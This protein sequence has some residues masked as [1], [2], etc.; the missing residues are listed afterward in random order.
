M[1]RP[2]L[3]DV[4][5]RILGVLIEKAF[6]TP[7]QYPLSINAIINGSN[8]KSN[9]DPV[10][11]FTE[12]EIVVGLQGLVPKHLA[13]RA[14][15][16]SSRVDKYQHSAAQALGLERRGLAILAELLMRGP[17]AQGELRSRVNRMATTKSLDELNIELE[18][19]IQAGL[20]Q[21]VAPLP[22]SRA[23][24]YGQL[25]APGLYSAEATPQATPPTPAP[26]TPAP[27]AAPVPSAA[28]QAERITKLE[29]EVRYLKASVE[30]LF[31]IIERKEWN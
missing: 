29:G 5:A 18:K 17:Q 4:E 12:A 3:N 27:T 26:A 11:S 30:K 9:R 31:G 14:M 2:T 8:Q 7:D 28:S 15:S 6:T 10:T 24:R 25:L 16:A 1:E 19:M 21:R 23:T 20:V 22:G 13:G